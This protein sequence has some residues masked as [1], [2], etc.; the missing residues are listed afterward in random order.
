VGQG[1]GQCA[2]CGAGTVHGADRRTLYSTENHIKVFQ[3]V[4]FKSLKISH[5]EHH[6][7][8]SDSTRSPWLPSRASGTMMMVVQLVSLFSTPKGTPMTTSRDW[9]DPVVREA[10]VENYTWHHNRNSFASRLAMSG[11]D[12]RT[13]AQLMGHGTIQMSMR[14]AHCLQTT[15]KQQLTTGWLSTRSM[16]HQNGHRTRRV[17][18]KYTSHL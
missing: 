9:F 7:Q 17:T 18:N 6:A 5:L 3:P 16:G 12:I 4:K 1:P 14:Y 8:I 11:A 15:T 2:E 13:I 10:K